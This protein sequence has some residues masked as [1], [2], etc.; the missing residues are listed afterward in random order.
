[1]LSL[2][3]SSSFSELIQSSAH[4]HP[5]S[6][7]PSL[8]LKEALDTEDK[9]EAQ[10]V[11]NASDGPQLV[12]RYTVCLCSSCVGRRLTLLT[13]HFVLVVSDLQ[14]LSPYQMKS[15]QL[16]ILEVLTA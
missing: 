10:K 6:V 11:R 2:T 15:S 4:V 13:E 7:S 8:T 12:S 14:I 3:I 1:M 5:L 16:P 9:S